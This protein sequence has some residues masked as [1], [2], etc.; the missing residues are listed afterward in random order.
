MELS[1]R[2]G[3]FGRERYAL[4]EQT[5][6]V[7]YRSFF[8][9]SA[10]SLELS[11]LEPTYARYQTRPRKW[12]LLGLISGLLTAGCLGLYFSLGGHVAKWLLLLGFAAGVCGLA[13]SLVEFLRHSRDCL[14]FYR[15]Y[16]GVPAFDLHW[17]KP[18]QE[19]FEAF[20]NELQRRIETAR[21]EA[22]EGGLAAELRGL[23][24]LKREGKLSDDEFRA[25][26]AMLLGLEPWQ[27][28]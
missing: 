18:N 1:Y 11:S 22:D 27:L 16:D 12:F 20:V 23:D 21:S 2:V 6:E 3:L 28:E 10:Y 14:T 26:K 25:A 8:N 5:L 19:S 17:Q 9:S 7:Y 15:S 4:K 24:R 13:V